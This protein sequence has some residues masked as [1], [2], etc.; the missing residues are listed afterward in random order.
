M[1]VEV[2]TSGEV[3]MSQLALIS[4]PLFGSFMFMLYGFYLAYIGLA[5]V[6]SKNARE[7]MA[8]KNSDYEK[9]QSSLISLGLFGSIFAI[10]GIAVFLLEICA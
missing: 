2:S 3:D 1:I 9:A 4:S 6:I 7:R 10:V 5:P 8:E